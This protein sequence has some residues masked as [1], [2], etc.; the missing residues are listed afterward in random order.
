MRFFCLTIEFQQREVFQFKKKRRKGMFPPKCGEVCG[1][2]WEKL[3]NVHLLPPLR[4]CKVVQRS[5]GMRSAR[6]SARCLL[7]GLGQLITAKTLQPPT[8]VMGDKPGN[9]PSD[10]WGLRGGCLQECSG[11]ERED[12]GGGGPV[13]P[14]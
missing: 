5:R 6:G 13:A 8:A 12:G 1:G 7:C 14:A 11:V 2:V 3:F 9:K 10:G 4:L